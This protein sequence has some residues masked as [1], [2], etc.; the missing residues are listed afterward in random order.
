MERGRIVLTEELKQE[1]PE[2]IRIVE[3]EQA[4]PEEKPK[5]K[6][7][8]RKKKPAPKPTQNNVADLKTLI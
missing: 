4:Q 7:P 6:R 2:E 1:T 8:A 5:R 3:P